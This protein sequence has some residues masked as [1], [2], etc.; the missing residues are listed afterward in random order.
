MMWSNLPSWLSDR[1]DD[2]AKGSAFNQVTQR[3]SRLGQ[4][5]GLSHNRLDRTGLKQRDNHVPSVSNGRRR[6]KEHVQTANAGLWHDEI[7][8]VNGCLTACGIS[9]GCE[10]S[11]QRQRSE[12]LAQDVTTDSVDDNVCAVTARDTTHAVT[13]LL[14]GGIDDFIESERLRL[15][16]FRMIG[17]A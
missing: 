3:I 8:H 13:Q 9:Q 7:C 1:E 12:R 16:G 2:P 6:L 15:L 14:Q 10:A 11:F 5:E 4:R 17:R